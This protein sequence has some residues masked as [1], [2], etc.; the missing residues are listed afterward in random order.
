MKL[1]LFKL[2]QQAVTSA[3]TGATT[4]VISGTKLCILVLCLSTQDNSKVLP[5]LKSGFKGTINWNIY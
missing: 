1:A 5:L 3:A 2:A 4:F